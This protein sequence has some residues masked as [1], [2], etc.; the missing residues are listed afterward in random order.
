MKNKFKL[1]IFGA[2]WCPHCQTDYPS[3]VGKY[4]KLIKSYDIEFV[5]ICLD[6][7]KEAYEN[8]LKEAPFYTFCDYLGWDSPNVKNYHVFATPTYILL[9]QELKILAKIQ[10]P[11]HLEAWLQANTNK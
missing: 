8:F 11:E 9:D 6:E 10:S 5:Y 3:L 2:S 7:D 4:K 1:L